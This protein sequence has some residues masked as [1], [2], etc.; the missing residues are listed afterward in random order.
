[1]TN[2]HSTHHSKE[3]PCS[4]SLSKYVLVP[5]HNSHSH[6]QD[7]ESPSLDNE[8]SPKVKEIPST[9]YLSVTNGRLKVLHGKCKND[10]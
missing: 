8:Y 2:D 5:P 3:P 7:K 9:E 10:G 6:M 1:M 4:N